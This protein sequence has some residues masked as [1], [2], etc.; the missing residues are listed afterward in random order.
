MA[1]QHKIS[2]TEDDIR[3]GIPEDSGL[4]VV[5][6][7]IAR[8]IPDAVRI[9]VD[10][11]TVR[12]THAVTGER[13]QWLTPY[14]VSEYVVNFDAGDSIKP[15]TFTLNS[16]D[17]VRI[18]RRV[19]SEES[20]EKNAAAQRQ[21]R[22]AAHVAAK[23]SPTKPTKRNP[24]P[25]TESGSE[26]IDGTASVEPVK[27]KRNPS[28]PVESAQPIEATATVEQPAKPKRKSTPPPVV[29]RGKRRDY[30][31]RALRI[32]QQV[33]GLNNQRLPIPADELDQ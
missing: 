8:H 26:K 17:R 14:A 2:V 10:L 12:F 33:R 30:G 11:R 22:A 19:R 3:R 24:S 15:F 21:R 4:C 29:R 7:A 13:V 9:S 32:N 18:Q 23:P 5:A 28:P 16:S 20:Y 1:T 25:P 31:M 6:T 27:P